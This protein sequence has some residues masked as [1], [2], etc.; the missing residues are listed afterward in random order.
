M[1]P[2]RVAVIGC[3]VI[4]PVHL[5]CYQQI[6]FVKIQWVCDI[7]A[8]RAQKT[9]EKFQVPHWTT[10]LSEVLAD[11]TVQAVSI[12]TDHASHVAIAIAALQAGKDILCEK[13]LT[14]NRATLSK[15]LDAVQQYPERITSGVFQ[16]RFD[17][18]HRATHEI[19]QEGL[20]GTLLTASA[21]LRCFRS[22][23]YYQAD[24]W[25]GTWA[26]EGGSAL[27]NQAIHF[28]DLLLWQTGGASKAT[29]FIANRTHQGVIETEDAVVAALQLRCGAL[30]LLEVTS[31]SHLGWENTLAFHGSQGSLEIRDDHPIKVKFS[32]PEV[33][34]QVQ[35]RLDSALAPQGTEAGK[36]YYGSGHPA[37]ILDFAEAVR[38]RRAPYVPL[39]SAAET[40]ATVFSIYESARAH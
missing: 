1:Q 27:I 19:L 11:P 34:K 14:Q 13:C 25:R 32:D 16:H 31:S 38:D 29:A 33:E 21:T 3:G 23:D 9:A 5:E 36:I 15:L 28:T 7:V 22:N 12:C 2:I 35:S 20:L 6:D 18:I 30:G 8:E 10:N 26:F 17:P 37:Q 24:A 39:V 4:G 40:A